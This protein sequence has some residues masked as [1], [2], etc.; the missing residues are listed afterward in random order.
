[1][2]QRAVC[3]E[4]GEQ[5]AALCE[6]S[7]FSQDA[8]CLSAAPASTLLAHWA[9]AD[10]SLIKEEEQF[11]ILFSFLNRISYFHQSLQGPLPLH[12]SC[13]F[14]VGPSVYGMSALK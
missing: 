6:M 12:L 1:M 14:A 5:L 11:E 10:V 8:H 13:S 9:V 3:H 4:G 7:E 2:P